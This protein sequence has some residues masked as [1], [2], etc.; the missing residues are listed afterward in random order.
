MC[1][2]K[3]CQLFFIW[4]NKFWSYCNE[5]YNEN[6]ENNAV[7]PAGI[8]Q[9]TIELLYAPKSSDIIS[10]LREMK[11]EIHFLRSELQEFNSFKEEHQILKNQLQSMVME[12]WR[13]R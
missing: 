7:K 4:L 8:P 10:E 6:N 1:D 5:T 12:N 2:Q 9:E 3:N 13:R 11:S